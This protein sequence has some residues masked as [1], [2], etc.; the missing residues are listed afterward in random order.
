MLSPRLLHFTQNQIF[1]DC[2]TT[3]ACETHPSGLPLPLD[4][5]AATDRHWRGRLNLNKGA[6]SRTLSG[7]VDNESSDD[8]W[9]SAIQY[10]TSC[11]LTNQGD[12]SVAIWS[13]AKILR[14]IFK[15]NYAV[16][17]WSNNL[18]EQLAWRVKDAGKSEKPWDLSSVPSWSWT[19]V[20][21]SI[22]PQH[23]IAR[24]TYRVEDPNGK[25]IS[26]ELK[27]SNGD[28]DQEPKL[29]GKAIA[30]SGYI[31]NGSIE[32][33]G[34]NRDEYAIKIRLNE[35][36]H[37]LLDA[38]PDENPWK[39]KRLYS[40]CKFVVLAASKT[41]QGRRNNSGLKDTDETYGGIGL[42]LSPKSDVNTSQ[43]GNYYRRI[44]A[45][46]FRKVAQQ[47]FQYLQDGKPCN[48][49]LE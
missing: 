31:Y 21:G 33:R 11:N 40:N 18:E 41:V 39:N 4:R 29:A 5:L 42:I 19:N 32:A 22:L 26:F 28:R 23:R 24:R 17:M 14:D 12:K 36:K 38:F 34:K 46:H 20:K 3:S 1:W 7:P 6:P 43:A 10:Y 9:L 27:D 25:D 45:V 35:H 44:G 48:F 13:V 37:V 47:D 2:C 8:F 30:I 49:W 15:E 16:G